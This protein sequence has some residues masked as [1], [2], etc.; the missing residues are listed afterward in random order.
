MP[1]YLYRFRRTHHLLVFNELESQEIFFAAPEQL[2]DPMEGFKD[3]LW[4]GD[5]VVWKNLLKHYLLCLEHC[6]LL[7]IV[8]GDEHVVTSKDIPLFKIRKDFPTSKIENI[9]EDKLREVFSGFGIG[10]LAEKLSERKKPIRRSELIF[11][12]KLLHPIA[13]NSIFKAYE[14]HGFVLPSVDGDHLP[15]IPNNCHMIDLIHQVE[16]ENPNIDD[17]AEKIY[18]T[19]HHTN[20]QI[21]LIAQYNDNIEG[22]KLE[23]LF[24]YYEFPEAYVKRLDT[25]IFPEW[26]VACFMEECTNSS[27]WGNYGDNHKGVCLIFNTGTEQER[28]YID[29]ECNNRKGKGGLVRHHFSPVTYQ[30][31]AP[32]IDF[33]DSFGR[34]NGYQRREWFTG[35]LAIPCG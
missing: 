23:R 17:I 20:S 15:K 14:S 1:E 27:A 24:L 12:L 25:L 30:N 35:L 8:G 7:N 4:K 18:S 31:V 10:Q 34:L 5:K 33:F 26:Y 19:F 9:F 11:H 22:E 21:E 3:I 29:L 13:I 16:E 28:R 32:T 6:F 2:N